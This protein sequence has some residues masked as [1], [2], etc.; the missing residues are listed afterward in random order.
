MDRKAG[1][2]STV[3]LSQK[4]VLPQWSW[5]KRN[6]TGRSQ[7]LVQSTG[8]VAVRV[9]APVELAG[10]GTKRGIEKSRNPM[11][12]RD[13]R[14]KHNPEHRWVYSAITEVPPDLA[15]RPQKPTKRMQI[16]ESLTI[17]PGRCQLLP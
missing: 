12:N 8:S 11:P 17:S 7:W 16:A 10:K 15:Y 1:E 9:N 13:P 4:S 5:M 3:E 6:L 2:I 14:R